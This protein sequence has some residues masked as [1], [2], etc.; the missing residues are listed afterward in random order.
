M[1]S[2]IDY[3][4][5]V[6]IQNDETVAEKNKVTDSDMN[7]IKQAV[8]NNAD[9]LEQLQNKLGDIEVEE[10]QS[11]IIELEKENT[12]LKSQIPSGEASGESIH[13]TDSSDLKT[14]IVIKG[15]AEQEG[16]PTPDN[17]VNIKTVG[18]GSIEIK[19][20]NGL[21]TTDSNYQSYIKVLPV[22]K[23]FVKINDIEDTFIKQD[24]KWCEKHY[25]SKIVFDGTI[26][27]FNLKANVVSNIFFVTPVISDLFKP[28][29]N[30]TK[31]GLLSNHFKETDANQIYLN[32]IVG[33]SAR[34]GQDIT[35]GFGLDSKITTLE[36]AN[37]WLQQKNA[38][39]EPLIIYYKLAEPE[40]IPCTE[41]QEE[42]LNS[43]KTY[44]N[45][46]NIS[47]DSIATLNVAYKKDLE[48]IINS[49]SQAILGGN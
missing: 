17:P 2:K 12:T 9:E 27:K 46:T 35:V 42:V 7:K 18:Q 15:N 5:K 4:D 49:L 44:K 30:S 25:Y 22:Q 32:N 6:G 29:S 47:T 48:T 39:G 16:E 41:E 3:E 43:F 31:V 13:L 10:L 23:E 24:G 14:E 20:D 28:A 11:Q 36:L 26:N 21:E 1:I 34:T 38:S 19:V 45:V 33:I 37:A 40:L 8:N